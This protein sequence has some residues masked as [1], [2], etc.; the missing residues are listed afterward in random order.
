MITMYDSI[1][2]SQIP[3]DAT[4]VAGYVS[5]NWP[6][7][8]ALRAKFPHAHL[9]SIATTAAHDA[10]VLDVEMGDATP[11]QAT[12]WIKRQLARGVHRSVIYANASTMPGVLQALTASGISRSSVR[13]WSAHYDGPHIC[14][15]ASC[16]FPGVPACDGTQWTSSALGRDLD[17]SLLLDDFFAT[18]PEPPVTLHSWKSDGKTSL[19][20]LAGEKQAAVSTILRVTAERGKYD[21]PFAAYIDAVFGGK[22]PASAPVPAGALLWVPVS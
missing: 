14:G 22:L 4:A 16:R 2:V 20:Q 15:P 17:E 13:L 19:A 11:G 18:P 12:G 1:Q 10:D 3:D 6:T 7:Y 21:A 8:E 9:L 5:G